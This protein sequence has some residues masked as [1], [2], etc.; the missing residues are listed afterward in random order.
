MTPA[1]VEEVVADAEE[2]DGLEGEDRGKIGRQ[3]YS[4]VVIRSSRSGRSLGQNYLAMWKSM[5]HPSNFNLLV[6]DIMIDAV[7][8]GR[9]SNNV[10]IKGEWN[11]NNGDKKVDYCT[12]GAHGLR[13]GFNININIVVSSSH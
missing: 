5:E 8:I 12:N 9:P 7:P 3:L 1:N 6:L 2:H 11:E 13:S 4:N 10:F